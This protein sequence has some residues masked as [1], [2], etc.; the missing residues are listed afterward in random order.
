MSR[1][2]DEIR[3]KAARLAASTATRPT[4]TP[5]VAASSSVDTELRNSVPT[6]TRRRP[7]PVRTRPVRLTVDV[8]PAMH[9]DLVRLSA[10]VAAEI[11]AVRVHGQEILRALLRLWSHDR[12][13]QQRVAD[14][15]LEG[16]Q[17][18]Q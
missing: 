18:R 15:I 2:A 9:A 10:D 14:V 1:K 13:L 3:A 11:G 12:D 16:R 5:E 6:E 4:P 8:S 7:A 17:E